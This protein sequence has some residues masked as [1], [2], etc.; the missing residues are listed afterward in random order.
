MTPRRRDAAATRGLLLEAARR[1][2]AVDGYANTY[3]RDIASDAGVNVALISR[4][5]GSKEGLFRACLAGTAD[6]LEQAVR[7][8]P[9]LDDISRL[10]TRQLTDTQNRHYPSRLLMLL[11]TSGDERIDELRLGILR[12]FAEKIAAAAGR[13][14]GDESAVLDAQF[15]LATALGLAILTAAGLDPL[16][17]ANDG[18]IDDRLRRVINS[19]LPGN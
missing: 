9:T 11:R 18:Q 14:P 16:V 15:V 8:D 10:I 5:Y 3:I 1:R 13:S 7:D 19:L 6:D 4:Y 12:S 17:S 2:F